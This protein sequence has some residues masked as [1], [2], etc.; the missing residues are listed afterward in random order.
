[1]CFYYSIVKDNTKQLADNKII[2]SEQLKLIED[3]YF[4]N[5]FS[6]PILPVILNGENKHLE[7]FHWGMVPE[8]IK[9]KDDA[10][11]FIRTYSTLNAR[12]EDVY[13]RKLFSGPIRNQ[14][15]LIPA[16]GFF[17]WK[18][19]LTHERK[20][21][22]KIPYYISLT[23]N[24]MFVFGGIWNSYENEVNGNKLFTFSII[25]TE[26]N[27]LMAEIHNTKKRMPLILKPEDAHIWLNNTTNEMEIEK[28]IKPF[29]SLLM[30]A[31]S[32]KK[33]DPKNFINHQSIM[34]EF[35]Y[36]SNDFT[37]PLTLF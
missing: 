37:K 32:I 25:T 8:N 17:E 22:E 11:K 9:S 14:R 19:V 1:M 29:D 5:G 23:Q 13:A 2:D 20:K 16:T 7:F 4:I 34:D 31:H 6:A 35:H 27:N 33:I 21:T 3:Q 28:I 24:E 18:H 26:A 36:P 12:G 10:L 30:K 15:C